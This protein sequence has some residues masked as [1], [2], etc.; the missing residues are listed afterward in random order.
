MELPASC[1]A[2]NSTDAAAALPLQHMFETGDFALR[3]EA[4]EVIESNHGST[5]GLSSA[6]NKSGCNQ[7]NYQRAGGQVGVQGLGLTR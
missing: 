1:P 4:G 6:D 5:F 2:S 3:N 7:N